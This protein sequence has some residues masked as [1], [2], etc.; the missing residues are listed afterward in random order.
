MRCAT[1]RMP[2]GAEVPMPRQVDDL[3]RTTTCITGIES[4]DTTANAPVIP[5]TPSAIFLPSLV[6]KPTHGFGEVP[7]ARCA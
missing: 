3:P 5:A 6:S 2:P 7:K 4:A 1:P